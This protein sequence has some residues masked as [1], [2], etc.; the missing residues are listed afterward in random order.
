LF[1]FYFR[2]SPQPPDY[3]N[4]QLPV[5]PRR[6]DLPSEAIFAGPVWDKVRVVAVSYTWASAEHP[7]PFGERLRDVARV[8]AWLM[9]VE[10][11]RR[12]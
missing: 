9:C 12:N 10:N 7:D 4:Q 3:E 6:Q 8:V 2:L 11:R 1:F 5:L